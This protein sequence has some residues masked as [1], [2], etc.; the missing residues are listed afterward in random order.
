MA[1]ALDTVQCSRG[2]Y[3]KRPNWVWHLGGYNKL[4]PFGFEIH[5]CIDGYSRG[6]L[7]LN[8][9]RSNKDQKKLCNLFSISLIVM[10]DV[11]CRIIADRGTENVFI[12][13]SQRFLKRNHE[14]I[15]AGHSSFLSGKFI[16]NQRKK[17][18][19]LNSGIHVLTGGY[20]L[21]KDL[22]SMEH[23][24]TQTLYK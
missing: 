23:T 7:W 4:K 1:H 24:I 10:K 11:P 13:G 9:L 8:L 2:V 12:A 20:S 14:D 19:G 21:S 22:F 18:F 15:L 3:S 16:S 6:V 17:R 5:G